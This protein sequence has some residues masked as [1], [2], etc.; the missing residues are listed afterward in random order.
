MQLC[1]AKIW[2]HRV[3]SGRIGSVASGA[4]MIM[5]ID[6]GNKSAE[7]LMLD[8]VK[9]FVKDCADTILNIEF[10]H[11]ISICTIFDVFSIDKEI[12]NV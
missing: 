5:N 12:S 1:S 11:V 7:A 10:S 8:F 4:V 9:L 6:N 2:S 3:K